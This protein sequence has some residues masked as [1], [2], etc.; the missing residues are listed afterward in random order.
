MSPCTL[1]ILLLSL[2]SQCQDN[3]NVVLLGHLEEVR[4]CPR[5]W[6]LSRDQFV[7]PAAHATDPG[8]VDVISMFSRSFQLDPSVVIGQNP[9]GPVEKWNRSYPAT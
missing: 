1:T 2:G 6:R 5:Q 4:N 9:I 7:L 8:G 3:S